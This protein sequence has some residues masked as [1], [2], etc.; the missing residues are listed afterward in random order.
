MIASTLY[1]RFLL[2]TIYHPFWVEFSKFQI[3]DTER[4]KSL[5]WGSSAGNRW[6]EMG[7]CQRSHF[8][9]MILPLIAM[10]K[11]RSD[12]KYLKNTKNIFKNV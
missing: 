3:V 10:V 9:S 12:E 11:S 2:P 8:L 1:Q 6:Q 4:Q 5:G 7:L